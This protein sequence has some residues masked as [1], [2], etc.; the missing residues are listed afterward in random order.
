MLIILLKVL[1]FSVDF[2]GSNL[3]HALDFII[4]I[5]GQRYRHSFG[6]V[7]FIHALLLNQILHENHCR[8]VSS[9]AVLFVET[10]LSNLYFLIF[11]ERQ[12]NIF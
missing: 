1:I 5:I 6:I 8:P 2:I 7:H 9:P 11:T 10:F 3:Y 12:V 4:F